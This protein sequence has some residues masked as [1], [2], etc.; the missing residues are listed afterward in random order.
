M[1]Q[2]SGTA[3]AMDDLGSID[4]P[5][6][7]LAVSLSGSDL[8]YVAYTSGKAL[9][10]A[11]WRDVLS[12]VGIGLTTTFSISEDTR[13]PQAK[14]PSACARRLALT[15]LSI[16][17]SGARQYACW[18]RGSEAKWGRPGRGRRRRVGGRSSRR[19]CGTGAVADPANDVV[20]I[21]ARPPPTPIGDRSLMKDNFT[22]R[23]IG[24]LRPAQKVLLD[25]LL[26]RRG[27][28][29]DTGGPVD[30]ADRTTQTLPCSPGQRSLWMLDRLKP[31]SPFYN[32]CFVLWV[33][34]NVDLAA[35]SPAIVEQD[36]EP[37]QK[38]RPARPF[39]IVRRERPT[40]GAPMTE[41]C[42]RKSN[43]SYVGPSISAS[44]CRSLYRRFGLVRPNTR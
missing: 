23:R 12:W 6:S 10:V 18:L 22:Q 31:G 1:R 28:R 17:C 2:L 32:I 4:A 33:E 19:R 16:S 30:C 40:G 44:A 26:R 8:C 35:M 37:M 3:I 36:G 34:G 39:E 20:I 41:W 43:L 29:V 11:V 14:L 7:P 5:T 9:L 15:F 25:E 21:A 27:L 13:W 38:I 24:P 42:T